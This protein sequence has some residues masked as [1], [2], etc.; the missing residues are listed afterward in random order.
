LKTG[1]Y[2]AAALQADREHREMMR[3]YHQIFK[4]LIEATQ[5]YLDLVSQNEYLDLVEKIF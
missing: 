4:E 2:T 3:E 5:E 1:N